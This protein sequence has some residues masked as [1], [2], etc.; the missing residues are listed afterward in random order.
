MSTPTE[1]RMVRS[2]ERGTF[3]KC[4]QQWY[5]AY[6][7]EIQPVNRKPGARDFGTGVHLALAEYYIPGKKRGKD[8]GET[9]TKWIDSEE[10]L[11]KAKIRVSTDEETYDPKIFMDMKEL[12]LLLLEEYEFIYGGDPHWEVIAPEIPFQAMINSE[13]VN[14]GTIDLVVR[15]LNDDQIKIVDHKTCGQFPNFDFLDLDDQCGSYSAIAQTI[16]RAKGLIGPKEIV[17]GMEYNYIRKGRPDERPVNDEG[18]SLNKDGS[19]SKRQPTPLMK[20]HFIRKTNAEKRRQLERIVD[21]AKLMRMA[22]NGD[23]PILKSVSRDCTW[24]DFFQLCRIDE[25]G[26]DTDM[27]KSRMFHRRD[28]YAD[29]RDGAENS[30]I[31]VSTARK[32]RG[33]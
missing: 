30:K 10:K 16:L 9:F 18:L 11:S 31:S 17:R 1:V 33:R 21:D 8:L 14:L 23:V 26:G 22:A 20:R 6:V 12:G 32:T 25:S 3:K 24:C 13:V 28:P 19:V 7:E 2:S 29:H 15:D 27:F 5:W 4:M